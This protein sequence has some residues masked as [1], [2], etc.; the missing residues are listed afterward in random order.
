MAIMRGQ[1][2]G[3]TG[4]IERVNTKKSTVTMSGIEM[5]KKDGTKSLY[6]IHVSNLSITELNL[7]DKKRYASVHR[8]APPSK[9]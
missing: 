1:F 8:T 4:R 9:K 5:S 7:D 3:K 2:A 6:P